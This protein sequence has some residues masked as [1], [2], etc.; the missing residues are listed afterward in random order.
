MQQSEWTPINFVIDY[1]HDT[2]THK[3]IDRE[4]GLEIFVD[5]DAFS[6]L[7][8]E[9]AEARWLKSAIKRICRVNRWKM[10]ELADKLSIS[11]SLISH[12]FTGRREPSDEVRVLIRQL[13]KKAKEVDEASRLRG[14]DKLPKASSG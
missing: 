8:G 5:R 1:D 4:E 6:E 3:I 7:Y 11:R 14:F 9:V 2:I 13:D 12:Y 10:F